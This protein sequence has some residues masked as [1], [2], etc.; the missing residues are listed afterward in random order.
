MLGLCGGAWA[1]HSVH[2]EIPKHSMG[3]N[4]TA[5]VH[6]LAGVHWL[7]CILSGNPG[8][9]PISSGGALGQR[10]RPL[11]QTR[12]L[13][14]QTCC[15]STQ[16]TA[17]ERPALMWVQPAS[18]PGQEQ[19]SS[20]WPL[21]QSL[22]SCEL[23]VSSTCSETTNICRSDDS[24]GYQAQICETNSWSPISGDREAL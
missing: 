11:T 3:Q 21:G 1:Q 24:C 17:S 22:L 2:S 14:P 16:D 5:N 15:P 10:L 4:C 13:S 7:S 8:L 18:V 23:R 20:G 12:S 9:N 19:A 6:Y